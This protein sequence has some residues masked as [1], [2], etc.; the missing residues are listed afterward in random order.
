LQLR[1]AG[2]AIAIP[3]GGARERERER[4]RERVGSRVRVWMAEPVPRVGV[5]VLVC[6]G[7]KVLI[8]RRRSSIGDGSFAL[9][10]GHLDF[11]NHAHVNPLLL[12]L[13]LLLFVTDCGHGF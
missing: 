11:G 3:S 1:K 9:P 10:G 2:I 7:S 4:E 5:G 6:R 8:G 13:L 12:L